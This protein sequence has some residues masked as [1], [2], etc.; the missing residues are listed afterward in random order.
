V[1]IAW[2]E[3]VLRTL[4]FA[5]GNQPRKLARVAS[6]GADAVVLD[7]EDAVAVGEK[8][9]ARELVREALRGFQDQS[10]VV[11]A[12]VN[13]LATGLTGDDLDA[14]VVPGLRAV[15]VP[16][17]E[18]PDDL[19]EVDSRLATLEARVGIPPGTIR[20]L[21][22]VETARG[23]ARVEDIARAAP[24]RVHALIFGQADLT[25]DLGIDLT[26]DGAEILYARSRVVVAARAADL[27][28]PIDGPY[29]D[30]RDEE[31]LIRDARRAR[32]L[33]FQG[34]VVVY[35][36]QVAP[37]NHAF[38]FVPPDELALAR[39]I[40]EA[41]E[42]AEAAGSAAIQVDGI[43]VDYPIYHRALRKLRLAGRETGD[44]RETPSP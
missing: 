16:K 5:P 6:F 37:V 31:G 43:F 24:S 18:A 15:L 20:L 26:N 14:V 27:A 19:R 29:L 10:P 11:M 2:S 41:F 17:V 36:P 12:R 39:K 9:K 40:V 32:Q 35:P 21:P 4:L 23:I 30:L 33:G 28:P 7:L 34:K 8:V 13:G 3:L 42:A 44:R 38:S 22:L 25:A 1:T